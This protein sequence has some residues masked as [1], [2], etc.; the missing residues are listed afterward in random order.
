[1]DEKIMNNY[2]KA[3]KIASKARD[4]AR[5]IVREGKKYI[6][7]A[8]DI[9]NFIS[10][11]GGNP[12]FPV[13]IS[14]NDIAAHYTPLRSDNSIVK[15]EDLI[16]IDIGVHIE[17]CIADT[18]ISINL[19]NNYDK[20]IE[21][22]EEALNEILS[23]IKPGIEIGKI[24]NLI[25]KKINSYGF[26]PVR[27]LGGHTLEIYLQHAG[28]FIPNIATDN[29]TRLEEDMVFAIEPFSTNGSGFVKEGTGGNIYKY[30][31]G[32]ARGFHERKILNTIIQNYRTLPF[33]PR[34]LNISENQAKLIL[35][36][37]T[38]QKILH[39][40]PILRE[41]GKGMVSQAEHTVIMKDNP[42][43]IT[44]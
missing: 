33:T 3:G 36:R 16:K 11:E 34:W 40:Y 17:G 10:K 23:V 20:L 15:E 42:I 43:I 26:L 12:A 35:S 19:N 22:S 14:V 1:M 39:H 28:I 7:I 8:E 5:K 6:E 24:G 27:N 4:F 41:S 31:G 13:N 18:A 30:E 37:L 9:E 25:Q 2:I 44:E 38:M 29:K 21:S 32:N